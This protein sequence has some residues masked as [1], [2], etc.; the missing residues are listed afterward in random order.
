MNSFLTIEKTITCSQ[1]KDEEEKHVKNLLQK[2]MKIFIESQLYRKIQS[3]DLKL[4]A[5]INSKL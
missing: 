3:L 2:V 5:F 4:Y 1:Y